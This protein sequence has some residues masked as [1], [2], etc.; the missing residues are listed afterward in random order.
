MQWCS[1]FSQS[2]GNDGALRKKN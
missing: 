2:T 1:H